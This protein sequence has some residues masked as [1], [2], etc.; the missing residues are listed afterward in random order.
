MMDFSKLKLNNREPA[1]IQI[2]DFIKRQILIKNALDGDELPSRR[3]LA[4][5][6][7]IN[8]NTVQKAYKLMEDE[9]FI[10]T[11]NNVRSV[12]QINDKVYAKIENELTV[13]MIKDFINSAKASGLTYERII[14][15]LAQ[16]WYEDKN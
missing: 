8:P 3:E 12:I 14:T 7:D 10:K 11:G 16:M 6:L 2:V 4:F 9:G 1:Y 15:L 13:S 5:I